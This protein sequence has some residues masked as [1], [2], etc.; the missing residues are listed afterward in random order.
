MCG[1]GI[2]ICA[3]LPVLLGVLPVLSDYGLL[4]SPSENERVRHWSAGFCKVPSCSINGRASMRNTPALAPRLRFRVISRAARPSRLGGLAGAQR[5]ELSKHL[6][7][8]PNS[9][10]VGV[11]AFGSSLLLLNLTAKSHELIFGTAY[12]L[13]PARGCTGTFSYGKKGLPLMY[14]CRFKYRTPP[15]SD[16][17][18]TPSACNQFSQS[19]ANFCLAASHVIMPVQKMRPSRCSCLL[20][21]GAIHPFVQT[22]RTD[23]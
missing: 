6:D 10:L 1:C 2:L 5:I 12:I 16:P 15:Q 14:T 22:S 19:Q 23:D 20:T 18:S 3:G 11:F 13:V 9:I 7:N 17:I 4:I 8:P 21:F